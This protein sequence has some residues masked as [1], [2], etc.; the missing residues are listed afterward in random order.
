MT[1]HI[2]KGSIASYVAGLLGVL[3]DRAG[4]L[5]A[6]ALLVVEAPAMALLVEFDIVSLRLQP[7]RTGGKIST[8]LRKTK[9][10]SNQ[11]VGGG[12]KLRTD[13][14]GSRWEHGE[15]WAVAAGGRRRGLT[16]AANPRVAR[17][18][19][20]GAAESTEKRHCLGVYRN[21]WALGCTVW[22]WTMLSVGLK[23]TMAQ[24]GML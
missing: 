24:N 19:V 9:V 6:L 4:L 17:G 14:I 16:M 5:L 18:L 7:T 13:Q 2:Y 23:N 3:L 22:D 1:K 15:V 8:K 11:R 12:G 10:Y 21:P 20:W